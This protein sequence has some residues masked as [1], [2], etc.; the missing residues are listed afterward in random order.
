MNGTDERMRMLLG[1][2]VVVNERAMENGEKWEVESIDF[3][4]VT[5]SWKNEY[6]ELIC[7]HVTRTFDSAPEMISVA[8]MILT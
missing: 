5:D 3:S 2:E 8:R 7:I 6:A 1:L 4:P